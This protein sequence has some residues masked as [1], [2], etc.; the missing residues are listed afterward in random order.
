MSNKQ[1]KNNSNKFQIYQ[2]YG[3][4]RKYN[5]FKEYGLFFLTRL[6]DL[7]CNVLIYI[8]KVFLNLFI[9]LFNCI[10][11]VRLDDNTVYYP[12]YDLRKFYPHNPGSIRIYSVKNKLQ[13]VGFAFE[14]RGI[15]YFSTGFFNLDDIIEI[16]GNKLNLY[17]ISYTFLCSE[18]VHN[19][20]DI[21][22]GEKVFLISPYMPPIMGKCILNSPYIYAWF[23]IQPAYYKFVGLPIV[24]ELGQLVSIYD[25]FKIIG[26]S[27]YNILGELSIWKFNNTILNENKLED[28]L[29]LQIYKSIFYLESLSGIKDDKLILFKITNNFKNLGYIFSYK[30]VYYSF[31]T[32]LDLNGYLQFKLDDKDNKIQ[33]SKIFRHLYCSSE[34]N[35][36]TPILGEIVNVLKPEELLKSI[37]GIVIKDNDGIWVE[38]NQGEY[39]EME[40]F[41]LP[42]INNFGQIVGLYGDFKVSNKTKKY[43]YR[44]FLGGPLIYKDYLVHTSLNFFS[45]SYIVHP[46]N[47]NQFQQLIETSLQKNELFSRVIISVGSSYIA[48]LLEELVLSYIK[49]DN[50]YETKY[51]IITD[52]QPLSIIKNKTLIIALTDWI[53]STSIRSNNKFPYE[54]NKSLLILCKSNATLMSQEL[55]ENYYNNASESTRGTFLK[56]SLELDNICTANKKKE[57]VENSNYEFEIEDS[58]N[59]YNGN[60]LND[61]LKRLIFKIKNKF[62]HFLNNYS[63]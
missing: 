3:D 59:N 41:G 17:Q 11:T 9:S 49:V 55:L 16:N 61:S 12:C 48:K 7:L 4:N 43:P 27:T 23:P 47:I 19:L 5:H 58:T 10:T 53:T 50:K 35:F 34:H 46:M 20:V 36:Y 2:K 29:K 42:L 37:S 52:N 38:F 6:K 56:V 33:F 26:D 24:N 51:C 1:I 13:E 44:V 31:D 15:Y 63:I 22:E 40:Y 8:I 57:L 21:K 39:P 60:T 28:I 62:D 54:D 14:Y 18:K 45:K 32:F 25:N 30:E